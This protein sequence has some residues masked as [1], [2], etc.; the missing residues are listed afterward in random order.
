MKV[1]VLG[2]YCYDRIHRILCENASEIVVISQNRPGSNVYLDN[3]VDWRMVHNFPRK[4]SEIVSL[5]HDTKVNLVLPRIRGTYNE[6]DIIEYAKITEQVD[7]RFYTHPLVFSQLAADKS[8]LQKVSGEFGLPVPN[9]YIVSSYT[10]AIH[11]VQ[12]LGGF[13]VVVKQVHA[14][15]GKGVYFIPSLIELKEKMRFDNSTTYLVQEF[16][17]GEEL[18]IEIISDSSISVRFPV[19]SMDKIDHNINPQARMR[20]SPY[21]MDR[22][23]SNQLEKLIDIIEG[24]FKPNGPW[25]LDLALSLSGKLYLLEINPRLGGLSN[26]S[27][28]ATLVDPHEVACL[29]ALNQNVSF[30][31]ERFLAIEIPIKRDLEIHLPNCGGIQF[32]IRRAQTQPNWRLSITGKYIHDI[33]AFVEKIPKEALL[34]CKSHIFKK[35]NRCSIWGNQN[36]D[37]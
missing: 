33:I 2:D 27:Y 23:I 24:V 9:G 22:N 26:L 25:Q 31:Q 20:Y 4:Q 21:K 29:H 18:G 11:A 5:I 30:P 35:L 28:Y 8:I 36:Y 13:P 3:K 34:V 19:I 17:Q 14:L 1:L 37:K 7:V 15:A 16:I 10:E 12:K 6:R 32:E